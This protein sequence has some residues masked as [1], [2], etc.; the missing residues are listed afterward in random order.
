MRLDRFLVSTGRWSRKEAAELIRRGEVSVDGSVTKDPAA[1][2]DENLQS[3]CVKGEKLVY[4][5][6]VYLMLNKPEGWVSSTDESGEK[7]VTDLLG[8][9][10]ARL[11]L[12]PL[13][14]LDKNTTGLLILTNDGQTAHR[15]LS[16]KHH[17]EKVY[18]Y[19]LKY[20]LSEA[21][22]LALEAGVELETGVH[23]L[24][25]RV[26]PDSP[27]SG[28]ITLTEGK[29]HQIKLM[30]KAVHNAVVSLE[31]VRFAGIPLDPALARGEYRELTEEEIAS[32]T[33]N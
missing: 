19:A 24:P 3:A 10:Y 12:F 4:R 23:T 14:R 6:F 8:A 11:G 27:V 26:C 25:C 33:A 17:A 9:E 2:L 30:A 31:R 18:R 32:L 7:V 13:G 28:T 5:R 20:P 15:L 21:D 1:K 22:R 29:F 16:P